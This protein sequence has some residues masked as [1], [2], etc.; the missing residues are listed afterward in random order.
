MFARLVCQTGVGGTVFSYVVALGFLFRWWFGEPPLV[1]IWSLAA[2]SGVLGGVSIPYLKYLSP[3]LRYIPV[4][5]GWEPLLTVVFLPTLIFA[6]PFIV[7]EDFV[8][9]HL[10]RR[11]LQEGEDL[12][13]FPCE[14]CGKLLGADPD[15]RVVICSNCKSEN[16]VPAPKAARKAVLESSST[17]VRLVAVDVPFKELIIFGI[18]VAI[19]SIPPVL[20]VAAAAIGVLWLADL[21]R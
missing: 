9:P 7:F 16:E 21:S 5:S 10:R 1:W 4:W 8:A 17:A 3:L 18:K 15:M 6:F 13:R 2:V 12:I 19:A 14:S 20:V 11:V